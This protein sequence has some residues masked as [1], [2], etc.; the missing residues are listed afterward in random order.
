MPA[1]CTLLES[2]SNSCYWYGKLNYYFALMNANPLACFGPQV[3]L[4]GKPRTCILLVFEECRMLLFS[5]YYSFKLNPYTAHLFQTKVVIHISMEN[6]THCLDLPQLN[7]S[8]PSS[9]SFSL[10]HLD[11]SGMQLVWLVAQP[12]QRRLCT[13]VPSLPM[14]MHTHLRMW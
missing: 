10:S 7:S 6:L 5:T 4:G 12:P 14:H 8:D 1:S 13:T 9:Q 11:W 3:Y 2:P